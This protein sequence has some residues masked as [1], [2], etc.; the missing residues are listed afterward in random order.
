MY[1]LADLNTH[2]QLL[3]LVYQVVMSNTR[4]IYS[5]TQTYLSGLN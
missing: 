1:V 5:V 3:L 4:T 2:Y